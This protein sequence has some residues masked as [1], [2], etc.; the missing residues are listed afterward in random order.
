MEFIIGGIASCLAEVITLPIDTIKIRI[1]LEHQKAT[2]WNTLLSIIRNEGIVA[3]FS[4]LTPALIR[5]ACYGSLRYGLY[6]Y[7]QSILIAIKSPLLL[8]L[9]AGCLSG[10]LASGLCN[11]TDLIKVRMQAQSKAILKRECSKKEVGTTESS[12][13]VYSSVFSAFKEI[14]EKEGFFSLYTG[15][16]PTMLRASVLASVEMTFYDLIK[17][18]LSIRFNLDNSVLFVISAMVASFFSA[19]ASNPFDVIRTRVMNQPIDPISKKGLLF[20]N[21]LDCAQKCVK[22]EGL[23]VLF[24][25]FWAFYTRLGPNTIITFFIMEKLREMTLISSK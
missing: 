15:V 17:D 25:G 21:T 23:S 20:K 1:Q 14:I 4:G 12:I 19:L 7:F 18:F 6:P 22:Q 16:V 9:G 11:P 13:Y 5:Q 24:K 8:K 2:F 3:L 10:A